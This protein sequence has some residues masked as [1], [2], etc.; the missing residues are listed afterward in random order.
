[1][2]EITTYQPQE[3]LAAEP[4]APATVSAPAALTAW[5]EAASAAHR[6]AAPLV[7]TDFVPAHFRPKNPNDEASVRTAQAAATAA[8]LYGAEAGLS[9]MQA[10]QSVYVIGGKP[11][12]YARAMHAVVLSAGHR[13]WTEESTDSKAI[14]CGQRRGGTTVERVVV[15]M[16]QARKAGWTTNKKYATEPATML[17]NRALSVTCRRVA[18]D[19]L[20]GMPYSAEELE[21]EQPAPVTTLRRS[22]PAE[23]KR[24]ARRAAPAPEPDLEPPPLAADD[25]IPTDD[26]PPPEPAADTITRDQLTR[27]HASFGDLGI[28]ERDDRLRYA[29]GV[30]GHDVASSKDLT[31]TQASQVLDA[32]NTDLSGGAA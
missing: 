7:M 20:A 30:L 25:P 11:A 16:D 24:T 22:A 23:P 2:S 6:L 18:P 17:Y 13:I 4:P 32:I 29:S 14:V 21:D 10:L 27:L 12:F 15:T 9:P 1:M 28:T 8:V 3:P 5:A 19:A 26:Q 31:R